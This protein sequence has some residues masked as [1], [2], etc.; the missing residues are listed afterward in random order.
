MS[1]PTLHEMLRLEIESLPEALAAEVIDFIVFLK[2]RHGEDVE[3]WGEV[4]AAHDRRQ[5]TPTDVRTV[6]LD[7]WEALADRGQSGR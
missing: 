4:V 3:L 2:T 7:E 1:E 6:A 5:S